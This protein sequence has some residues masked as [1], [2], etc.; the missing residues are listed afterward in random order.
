MFQNG[1]VILTVVTA[2]SNVVAMSINGTGP[3]NLD[4][5]IFSFFRFFSTRGVCKAWTQM[6]GSTRRHVALEGNFKFYE[7]SHDK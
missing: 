2:C 1:F 3:L 7:K 5:T 6:I 4:L